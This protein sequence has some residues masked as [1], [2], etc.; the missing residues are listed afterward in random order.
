VLAG[1]VGQA[2]RDLKLDPHPVGPRCAAARADIRL[3]IDE[4]RQTRAAA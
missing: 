4:T 1:P 3:H 2:D